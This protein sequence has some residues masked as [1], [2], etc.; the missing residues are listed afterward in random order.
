M[1]KQFYTF[2]SGLKDDEE[3]AV[4]LA[5]NVFHSINRLEEIN[6]VQAKHPFSKYGFKD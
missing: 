5:S 2:F 4:L 1:A 6:Q 3:R